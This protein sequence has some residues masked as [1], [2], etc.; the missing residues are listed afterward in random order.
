MLPT[1][2]PGSRFICNHHIR[3]CN[4]TFTHLI[5]RR[6]VPDRRPPVRSIAQH[7]VLLTSAHIR[8]SAIQRSPH[9]WSHVVHIIRQPPR[10]SSKPIAVMT[11]QTGSKRTHMGHS[12]GHGHHHHHD[13]TYLTSTNKSDAGVRITRIGLYV[14][15]GMAFGKG[16]GGYV[17]HSQAYVHPS[18]RL[19]G[20]NVEVLK[21]LT[22]Y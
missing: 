17:F 5:N 7:R 6:L 20:C 21:L 16:I 18:R 13:N 9:Q 19:A 10:P 4:T 12:H 3:T 2:P 11:S 15:L 8:S 22:I 14:N 1:P